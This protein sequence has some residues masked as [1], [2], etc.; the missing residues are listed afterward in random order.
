MA[1]FKYRFYNGGWSSSWAIFNTGS[2]MKS[3]VGAS[4]TRTIVEIS[5]LSVTTN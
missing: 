2:L 3:Y 5:N 1:N 4:S